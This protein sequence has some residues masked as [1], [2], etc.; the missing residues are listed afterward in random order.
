MT[1]DSGVAKQ[2]SDYARQIQETPLRKGGH[3]LDK[4]L[5]MVFLA[6]G[7]AAWIL[8]HYGRA[9]VTPSVKP[10]SWA[11][12]SISTRRAKSEPTNFYCSPWIVAF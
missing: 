12:S 6:W 4:C 9:M 7:G 2:Y 3:P 8:S 5:H 1:S 10:S 11:H